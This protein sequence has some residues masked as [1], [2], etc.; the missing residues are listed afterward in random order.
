MQGKSLVS[1]AIGVATF[2]M[3][4]DEVHIDTAHPT[5]AEELEGTFPMFAPRSTMHAQINGRDFWRLFVG[6]H[7][8]EN[9]WSCGSCLVDP[10][11]PRETFLRR[12]FSL[13]DISGCLLP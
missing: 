5:Q 4:D 3:N 9:G 6:A 11:N 2:P 1:H 13:F 7:A 12:R 8:G 10:R